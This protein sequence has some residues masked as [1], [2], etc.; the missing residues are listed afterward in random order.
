LT[1][2]GGPSE[3]AGRV[4]HVIH[5]GGPSLC[6]KESP[7]STAETTIPGLRLLKLNDTLQGLEGSNPFVQ[8][9]DIVSLPEADQVFVVGYVYQPRSIALKDK[10]ITVSRAVAM[11]GGPQRDSKPT[12]I[13]IVR[14]VGNGEDK[15]EI[16]VDLKAIEKHQAVD[17]V[18]LPNDIVDVPSSTGKMI[19]HT[20]TGAIVPVMSQGVIRAIP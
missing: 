13:R 14:Q 6:Q 19:L 17:I 18:L 20:L 9:G 12:K 11:A 15:E 2:A 16:L 3:K 10:T 8:P 5:A 7:E 1:F 4:I